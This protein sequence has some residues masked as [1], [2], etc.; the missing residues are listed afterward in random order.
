[1]YA[2][3]TDILS[4]RGILVTLSRATDPSREGHNQDVI[5]PYAECLAIALYLNL[6]GL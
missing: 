1:M 5:G 3:A 4:V 6:K 2:Y